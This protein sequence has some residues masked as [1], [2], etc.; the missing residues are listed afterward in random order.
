MTEAALLYDADCG[1]CRWC[2]ARILAWDRRRALRP[3]AIQSADGERLLAGVGEGARMA[4]WHLVDRDGVRASGGGAVAPLMRLL[5]G[6]AAAAAV[7]AR[8][9]RA[10]D[11]AYRAVVRRRG[12][13]GWLVG[14]GAAR[15]AR[16][17]IAARSAAPA[18][19]PGG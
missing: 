6:G 1:F 16:E 9:P 2:V 4:S 5:P 17:R 12:L 13:L 11:A 7:A 10:V 8:F 19:D 18:R 3:V 14:E 15:R